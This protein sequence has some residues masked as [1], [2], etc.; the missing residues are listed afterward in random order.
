MK[1]NANLC[2]RKKT[3]NPAPKPRQSRN[4]A[5]T[6]QRFLDATG[7]IIQESGIK[8]L[9]INQIAKRAG[10]N[11]RLIYE[12][13]E[14]LEGLIRVYFEQNDYWLSY[15][16]KIEDLLDSHM[17]DNGRELSS[18]LLKN[19]FQNFMSN[20]LLQQVSI[21]E[22]TGNSKL[23]YE[24][25]NSRELLGERFFSLS[26]D[27]FRN[28]G[29]DIR[30]IEAL[31]IGGINYMV[32]HSISN[33]STFCGIDIRAEEG[34]NALRKTLH[35]ITTWAYEE[36]EGKKI[37]GLKKLREILIIELKQNDELVNFG[38]VLEVKELALFFEVVILSFQEKQV[39]K[40]K[41]DQSIFI[42]N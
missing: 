37:G 35:Q 9:R 29:I 26:A 8:A 14:N 13:F 34:K 36:A 25:S 39:Y 11:K 38:T 27:L 24:L 18:L 6:K 2:K 16:E 42:Q 3:S 20:K 31:L 41:K 22:L 33:G 17:H 28:T 30:V 19:H 10:R 15:A 1:N 5:A 32:L 4:I 23:L 21:M 7:E 12:Y 40:F